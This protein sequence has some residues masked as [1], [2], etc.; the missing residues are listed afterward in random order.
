[1]RQEALGAWGRGESENVQALPRQPGPSGLVFPALLTVQP[2]RAVWYSAASVASRSSS[3][4][5]GQLRVGNLSS[6]EEMKLR[7]DSSV[8]GT[9]GVG[10]V[11]PC[12]SQIWLHSVGLVA[13]QSAQL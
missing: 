9:G 5:R 11:G 2:S 3:W 8:T 7:G 10:A 4:Y 1:M 6:W 13:H 12:L